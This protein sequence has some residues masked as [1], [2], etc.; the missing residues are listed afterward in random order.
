MKNAALHATL[1]EFRLDEATEAAGFTERLMR[2]QGWSR[3]YASRAVE[4]YRRFLYLAATGE[5]AVTPSKAVDEVWHL[6]LLYTRSYWD[7]LC[8]QTLGRP[9]HH[10][11]ANGARSERARHNRQYEATLCRYAEEFG[12]A[13][14]KDLWPSLQ[15]L[16][17]KQPGASPRRRAFRPAMI[18]LGLSALLLAGGASAEGNTAVFWTVNIV[19]FLIIAYLVIKLIMERIRNGADCSGGGCTVAGSCGSY[20]SSD[21]S[22]DNGGGDNGDGGGSSCGSGCGSGC[23]G[24]GG[25]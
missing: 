16:V 8:G 10:D 1:C 24:G 13:P 20:T 12:A 11:P 22:S 7:H 25:D 14:P 2:E 6:H 3:Q 15:T 21:S 4:E 19:V 5:Q 17:S 9:L 23:G 18:A